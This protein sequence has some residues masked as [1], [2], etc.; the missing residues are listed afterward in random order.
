[1]KRSVIVLLF[2]LILAVI[3]IFNPLYSSEHKKEEVNALINQATNQLSII[4]NSERYS[5]A[6]D[7][8]LK[9]ENHL[10]LTQKLLADG[11]IDSA[12]YEISIGILYFQMIE[13]RLELNNAIVEFD[14]AK[15]YNQ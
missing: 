9:I 1:M 12:F 2:I 10:N 13:A 11:K 15:K 4:K 3:S 5:T 14:E 7:E 6:S 8:I